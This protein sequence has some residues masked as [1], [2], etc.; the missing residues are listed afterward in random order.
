MPPCPPN[1]FLSLRPFLHLPVGMRG[2]TISFPSAPGHRE[3][4]EEKNTH[5]PPLQP[6]GLRDTP[7]HCSFS[8]PLACKGSR[9]VGMWLPYSVIDLE[10]WPGVESRDRG[11]DEVK[12]DLRN[13]GFEWGRWRGTPP[14]FWGHISAGENYALSSST[15]QS[16]GGW[17]AEEYAKEKSRGA[18]TW[19]KSNSHRCS[20]SAEQMTGEYS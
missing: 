1:P 13:W 18:P 15:T 7:P 11:A 17:I 20:I 14:S 9:A 12:T 16:N 3:L 6:W 5:I 2:G 4:P 10:S 19:K 8:L